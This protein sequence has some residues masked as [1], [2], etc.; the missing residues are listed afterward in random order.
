MI[1]FSLMIILIIVEILNLHSRILLKMESEVTGGHVSGKN[2]TPFI[3]G[4]YSGQILENY[5]LYMKSFDKKTD[6]LTKLKKN[7]KFC[8]FLTNQ[9]MNEKCNGQ[10]LDALLIRPIQRIPSLLLLYKDLHKELSQID[11]VHSF[12]IK[13]VVEQLEELLTK[14]NHEKGLDE[15]RQRLLEM[16]TSIEHFPQDIVSSQRIAIEK[17]TIQVELDA[18]LDG[19]RLS[20]G[21]SKLNLYL[22]TDLLILTKIKSKGLMTKTSKEI[23]V[24][25]IMHDSISQVFKISE[26]SNEFAIEFTVNEMKQF[27][28]F[29]T[30][31]FSNT[32]S[33]KLTDILNGIEVRSIHLNELKQQFTPTKN[34]KKRTKSTDRFGSQRNSINIEI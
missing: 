19:Y 14:L 34:P 20:K 23:Y 24:T 16:A 29:S 3:I 15:G 11:S 26:R 32:F 6:E 13:E 27:L 5:G 33:E 31:D 18:T 8:T 21:K 2:I 9:L 22:L 30:T 17:T 10:P 25:T 12:D 1:V 28:V 7:E 4:N